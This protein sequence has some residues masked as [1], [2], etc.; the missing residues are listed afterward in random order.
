MSPA[1]AA[2]FGLA[3]SPSHFAALEGQKAA[4]AKAEKEAAAAKRKLSAKEEEVLAAKKEIERLQAKEE[5]AL[6]ARKE[7][8]RLQGLVA[9]KED[10]V[11]AANAAKEDELAAAKQDMEKKF[12]AAAQTVVSTT[13][14]QLQKEL[15][16]SQASH[17]ASIGGDMPQIEESDDSEVEDVV[18]LPPSSGSWEWPLVRHEKK[19][20]L[21]L[22]ERQEASAD[23]K[24]LKEKA[25]ENRRLSFVA[26]PSCASMSDEE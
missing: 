25:K 16:T 1:L 15:A 3:P 4:S 10:E 8:E 24:E 18:P 19:E 5:E 20:R 26:M 2:P 22:L 21:R 11:A 13:V 23:R 14:Q 9:A 6:A 17:R 12:A 7:I